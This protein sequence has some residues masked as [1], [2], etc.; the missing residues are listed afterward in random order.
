MSGSFSTGIDYTLLFPSTSS[1]N[2]TTSL[3]TAIYGGGASPTTSGSNSLQALQTAELNQTTDIATEARQP[4]IAS[5]IA[6]FQKGVAAATTPAQLLQN[7]AVMKVLMTANGLASQIPYTALAQ[8]VLLSDPTDPN[9]LVNQLNSTNSA[10]LPVVQTYQF[11]SKG[12]SVIQNP[13]VISTLTNAYAEVSWRQS[14][15]ATT[16]GLSNALTF[17]Q[18]AGSITSA[19]Q[20]LGDATL[21]TVVTTALNIPLQIAYQDLGAQ[22]Q[23]ITSQMDIS[24]L[25]DPKFAQTIAQEY[26]LNTASAAQ[27]NGTTPSLDA[28]AI[29]ATGLVV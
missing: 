4:Q 20:I 9:S 15:D 28:L 22:A 24:R 26:L 3:L 18:Q 12:L 8:K 6:A 21:R 19:D 2:T 10:W 29:Q 13:Q 7:P 1:T 23:A 11:A 25:S 5:D 27:S 16:P 14:L 17:L